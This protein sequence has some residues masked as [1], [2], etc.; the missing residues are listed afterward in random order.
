VFR[1]VRHGILAQQWKR[2]N[3]SSRKKMID[4]RDAE[5]RLPSAIGKNGKRS[6]ARKMARAQQNDARGNLN[7][8]VNFPGNVTRILV[9]SMGNETGAWVD[10]LFLGAAGKKRIDGRT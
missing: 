1:A 6:A 3:N 2:A 9:S 7:S 10:Y 8:P 4:G 5:R